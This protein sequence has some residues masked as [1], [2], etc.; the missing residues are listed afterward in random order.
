MNFILYFL[1]SGLAFFTGAALVLVSLLLRSCFQGKRFKRSVSYLCSV[2]LLCVILSATPFLIWCYGLVIGVTIGWLMDKGAFQTKPW[3]H[4]GVAVLWSVAIG[5]EMENQLKPSI[6][7]DKSQP[8]FV[9]GDSVTA[10][11][12]GNEVTWPELLEDHGFTTHN[13]AQP[14]VTTA[15]AVEQAEQI[16][17]REALVIIEIGGNDLLGST[18]S[19]EFRRDLEKLLKAVCSPNRTVLMFELPLLPFSNGFGSAQ[20]ELSRRYKVT[21]IPKRLF[22]GVFASSGGTTDSIHLSQSGH[23]QM[24]DLVQS[25]IAPD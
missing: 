3:L 17:D 10:G 14:G 25:V 4:F 11:I 20:R 1:G 22:M 5:L 21:L 16:P 18:S 12:G 2:G 8:I 24:A 23:Q 6:K 7:A 9:I 19:S 15:E 13:L